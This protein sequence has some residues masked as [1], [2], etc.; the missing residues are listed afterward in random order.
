MEERKLK[1]LEVEAKAF[2]ETIGQF[3]ELK[4]E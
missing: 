1:D 2:E 4:L 3:E